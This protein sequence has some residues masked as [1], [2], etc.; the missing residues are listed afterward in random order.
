[1]RPHTTHVGTIAARK[2]LN[3]LVNSAN[4]NPRYTVTFTD[5][6]KLH[7]AEDAT[8]GYLI[9][10]DEYIGRP[11]RLRLEDGEI[12]DATP[13]RGV[14]D[15]HTLT[16]RYDA[17]I[18]KP[19]ASTGFM[20]VGRDLS[21]IETYAAIG[22]A[23]ARAASVGDAVSHGH[24]GDVGIHGDGVVLGITPVRGE[25]YVLAWA[26]SR[27]P[28]RDATE[29][30]A[31]AGIRHRSWNAYVSERRAPDSDGSRVNDHGLEVPTWS[32]AVYGPWYAARRVRQAPRG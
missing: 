21:P 31:E 22:A 7:T 10:N 3:R 4:G 24:P 18:K 32:D 13:L 8:I 19:G 20:P 26:L 29:C 5:G 15:G 25:P 16:P 30:A 28:T 23:L 27:T 14:V 17:W 11:L 2:D 6:R 1:M 9:T 12:A